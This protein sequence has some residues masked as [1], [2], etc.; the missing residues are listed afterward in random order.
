VLNALL[1]PLVLNPQSS[2]PSLPPNSITWLTGL[3]YTASPDPLQPIAQVSTPRALAILGILAHEMGHVVWWEND[4][5]NF[6]CKGADLGL[7]A[8]FWA[9]SWTKVGDPPQFRFHQF[10]IED[11]GANVP[12]GPDKDQVANDLL[13]VTLQRTC[14]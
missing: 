5:F 13:K 7:P 11:H 6:S 9:F 8:H 12:I 3:F 4:I 2:Q 10:G 1:N 14:N